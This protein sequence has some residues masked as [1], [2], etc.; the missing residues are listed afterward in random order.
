MDG[1]IF[2]QFGVHGTGEYDFLLELRM[3]YCSFSC[4]SV[5]RDKQMVV[6]F[7]KNKR[8]VALKL[9]KSAPHYT[10]AAMDEIEFL[11]KVLIFIL[12]SHDGNT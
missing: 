7:R 1:D 2:P 12:I 3:G 6:I 4:P 11:D 5:C 10:E 8:Q 9:Q